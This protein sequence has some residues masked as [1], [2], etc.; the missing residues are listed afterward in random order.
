MLRNGEWE[1][2]RSGAELK[3]GSE[4]RIVAEATNAPPAMYSSGSAVAISHNKV[5]WRMWR[6]SLPDAI[7]NSLDRWAEVIEVNFA[8]P[9][10]EL[11]LFGVPHG[12]G[13]DGPIFAMGHRF[14]AKVKWVPDEARRP[15]RCARLSEANRVRP[16]Q[17]Q[18][19]PMY[20]AFSVRDA[21]M[22]TL[23]ANYDRRGSVGIE[24]AAAA[25]AGRGS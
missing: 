25:N 11:S 21:G 6:V 17:L 18:E 22:T 9:A 23:T 3:L 20:L 12:F 10:D 24:T 7:S 15:C 14:I 13:S 8:Q 4:I 2:L 16:G 5:R 1:R 19:S